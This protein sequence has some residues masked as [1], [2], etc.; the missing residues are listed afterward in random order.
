MKFYTKREDKF[1]R[2]NCLII[3]TKRMSKMLGR[4]ESS[5]RQRIKLLGIVI[6][7]EIIQKFKDDSRIKKGNVP[8]NKGRKQTEYMSKEGIASSSATRFKKGSIPPNVKFN[9]HERIDDEGYTLIRIKPGKYV[10][11]HRLLWEQHNGK[12][13]NGMLIIFKDGNNKNIKLSNLEM[14]TRK[15]NMLRNTYHNLPKPLALIVQ[16]RGALNRQI[17]KHQKLISNAK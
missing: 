7:P 3:P 6:P 9:G 5:A 11:K 1:L 16:L 17:N 12:I 15:D 13:P 4:S 2:D 8:Q 14:I 10:L